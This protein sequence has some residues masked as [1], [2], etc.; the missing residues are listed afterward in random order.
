MPIGTGRPVDHRRIG[1]MYCSAA[2][3]FWILRRGLCRGGLVPAGAAVPRRWRQVPRHRQRRL[4]I[5]EVVRQ[6]PNA[7]NLELAAAIPRRRAD[8]RRYP[9][10]PIPPATVEL[11]VIRAARLGVELAV[12]PRSRWVRHEDGRVALRFSDDEGEPDDDAVLLVL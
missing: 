11:L 10:Q 12:V 6:P 3:R 1:A 2:E 5:L 8:L 4:A 9:A 7:A